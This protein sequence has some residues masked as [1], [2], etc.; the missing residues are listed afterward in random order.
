MVRSS[1][2]RARALGLRL[3]GIRPRGRLASLECAASWKPR[4]RGCAGGAYG[5]ETDYPCSQTS[6]ARPSF[7]S[8]SN[9]AKPTLSS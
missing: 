6:F 7:D 5:A 2:T 3:E 4:A 1:V 9:L 8:S